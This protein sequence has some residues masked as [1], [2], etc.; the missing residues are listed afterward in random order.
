MIFAHKP[1]AYSEPGHCLILPAKRSDEDGGVQL[2]TQ[3]EGLHGPIASWL[4]YTGIRQIAA[5]H[6]RLGLVPAVERDSALER[7]EIAEGK[8]TDAEERIADLEASLEQIVG[9]RRH[10]YTIQKQAKRPAGARS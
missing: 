8:L 6:E 7:A 1:P 5:K 2:Q 4:S 9:M 3:I 10:G